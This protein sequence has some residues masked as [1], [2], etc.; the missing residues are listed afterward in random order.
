[1]AEI[2]QEVHPYTSEYFDSD[3]DRLA[4]KLALAKSSVV[5]WALRELRMRVMALKAHRYMVERERLARKEERK[6]ARNERR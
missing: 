6:R 4:N 3:L 5:D 2:G 1:M